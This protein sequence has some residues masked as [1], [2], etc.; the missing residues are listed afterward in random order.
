MRAAD[1]DGGGRPP[2]QKKR[3]FFFVQKIQNLTLKE[4]FVGLSVII[5][6]KKKR[7]GR[8]H[9]TV[10]RGSNLLPADDNGKS[11]PYCVVIPKTLFHFLELRKKNESQN[12]WNE[13]NRM[14]FWV[15]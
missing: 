5:I 8:I 2:R 15:F 9:L 11:D 12:E 13:L 7:N 1:G 6:G 3:F 14:N 4:F 10:A